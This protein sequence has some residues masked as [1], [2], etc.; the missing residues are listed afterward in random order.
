[1]LDKALNQREVTDCTFGK[2]CNTCKNAYFTVVKK[3]KHRI[4][5]EK[6]LAGQD[7]SKHGIG[8]NEWV[9]DN[10]D[11]KTLLLSTIK[12][13]NNEKSREAIES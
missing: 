9:F 3:D 12:R 11:Y 13:L 5:I 10:A 7:P 2:N 6:C 4:Q 1:M 8:C